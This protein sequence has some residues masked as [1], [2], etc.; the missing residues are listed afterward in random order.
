M[1]KV[2]DV[3]AYIL[4]TC[5][6]MT[7]MKL[8]KLVYYSYAWHLVWEERE[9]FEEPIEAWSNGPVIPK[10]F[11]MHRKRFILKPGDIAGD[12]DALDDGEKGSIDV[13]L[14]EFCKK[15]AHWLSE[16]SHREPPWL[17]ARKAAGL[18][19]MERGSVRIDRNA[20]FEYYDSLTTA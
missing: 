20:I 10:L 7:A 18:D 8:Q 4:S 12:V 17:D 19:P 13:V 16:L 3:A 5:G 14:A 1:V 2:Q 11:R 15:S 9:L 6:E